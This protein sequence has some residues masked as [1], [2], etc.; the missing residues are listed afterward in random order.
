MIAF[1]YQPSRHGE[2][3]RLWS[4]RIRLNEWPRYRV[5]ALHV[6]DKRVAEH[7]MR[8]LVSE[9]ERETHG[10]G[11]PQ[12]VRQAWRI[13]LIEHHARFVRACD[14]ARLS[15]NT[16][17]K[18]KFSLP[19]LFERC[20][21]TAIREITSSSFTAW[22]DTS[23]LSPKTLNDFLGSMRTFLLWMKRERLILA[24]PLSNVRKMANPGV[25]G[26]RRALSQEDVRRLLEKAPP[27]R[28][29]VYLAMIY[30]GLRRSELN[31][32]KWDDFDFTKNPAQ[33]KVPSSLS[34]N[35]KESTH[36]LRPELTETIQAMRP[37]WAKPDDFVFR[38]TIPR[39]ETFKKDLA[40][41]GI[42]FEDTRGR[43]V[44]IHA[45]R[46]TFGTMLAAS[47]I[48]PRVAMEMMRHSDMKL[49]MGVYTD[50]SQLPIIQESARLPSFR[51]TNPDANKAAASQTLQPVQN[52]A[53]ARKNSSASPL[54][55]PESTH[56]E[57]H[58]SLQNPSSSPHFRSV[59]AAA[60]KIR[61]S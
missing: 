31:G 18:Y 28:A 41:A 39:V 46:K 55:P 45:L 17:T 51:L 12:P 16:I 48:S 23:S 7:K 19:R 40:A 20:K 52:D 47:G 14:G 21:W 61:I 30:T 1:L 50:V 10:I 56:K 5:F 58:K 49:T 37:V 22:R 24:D 44:D 38:G 26:F 29:R 11:V 36:Y 15:K 4:A 33:L 32:L 8:E 60:R 42:P 25:G 53:Q 57:T 54:E 3:S 2:K 34:K 59:G 35:R 27:Y 43:R 9:L 6:T 13:P